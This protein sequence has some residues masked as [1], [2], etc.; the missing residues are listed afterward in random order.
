MDKRIPESIEEIEHSKWFKKLNKPELIAG[1]E[2][3]AEAWLKKHGK[4]SKIG[5]QLHA[6]LL[7]YRQSKAGN[8]LTPRNVAILAFSILYAVFPADAIADIIPVIGWMDDMGILSLAFSAIITS[9]GAQ[10]GKEDAESPAPATTDDDTPQSPL[11][12]P[13]GNGKN[14]KPP[15]NAHA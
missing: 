4:K 13:E 7:L 5:K 8:V 14:N 9:M 1:M 2:V 11:H 6:A 12:L 10:S 3:A 15:T